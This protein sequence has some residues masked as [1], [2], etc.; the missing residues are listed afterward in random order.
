VSHRP[1]MREAGM[2]SPECSADRCESTGDYECFEEKRLAEVRACLPD[3]APAFLLTGD[4]AGPV[5]CRIVDG[6]AVVRLAVPP[7]A[8]GPAASQ[9]VVLL[10][11]A[12]GRY[13]LSG[14]LV[15]TAAGG[16][17]L[18]FGPFT[19][20]MRMQSR[21]GRRVQVPRL[22]GGVLLRGEQGQALELRDISEGGCALRTGSTR[23][24]PGANDRLIL[25][26]DGE[27]LSFAVDRVAHRSEESG[28]IGVAWRPTGSGAM[29]SL[30][31]LLNRLE[32]RFGRP[33]AAP[34]QLQTPWGKESLFRSVGRA[35]G[36]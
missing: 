25:S 11:A 14:P 21:A 15:C 22:R 12:T 30:R 4:A 26:A 8:S 16:T 24:L 23:D 29:N 17:T 35:R 9:A 7:S 36:K 6:A 31:R 10:H 1:T 33:L 2:P 5:P 19:H 34:G 32:S 13:V 3:Q 18:V 28:L 20:A 27:A